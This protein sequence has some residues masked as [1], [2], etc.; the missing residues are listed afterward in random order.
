MIQFGDAKIAFYMDATIASNDHSE[1][2]QG[3]Y[4]VMKS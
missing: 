3:L 2:L 1:Y 4:D